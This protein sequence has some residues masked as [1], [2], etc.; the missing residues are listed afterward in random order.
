MMSEQS[1]F[2]TKLEK[3]VSDDR[4]LPDGE[5]KRQVVLAVLRR[6]KDAVPPEAVLRD[7]ASEE[8]EKMLRNLKKH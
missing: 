1:R 8:A 3:L 7:A 6:F 2:R 4:R 5:C